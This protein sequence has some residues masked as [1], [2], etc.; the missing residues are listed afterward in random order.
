HV[1]WRRPGAR[2]RVVVVGKGITFDSGGLSLKTNEGMLDMKTDMA[3]AA[4]VLAAVAA[5][6]EEKLGVEVHALAAC[7]ENMPSGNAYKLGDVI[8]T[9]GGQTGENTNTDAQGRR[10]RGGR[11]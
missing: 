11:P 5:A 9:L 10:S 2:R 7:T 6:A 8:R 3:G 4:A 1:A